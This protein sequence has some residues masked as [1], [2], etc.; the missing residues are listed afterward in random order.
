MSGDL[1]IPEEAVEALMKRRIAE[2]HGTQYTGLHGFA[3]FQRERP[4]DTERLREL[5]EDDIR[6]L[7]PALRKQGAEEE[8]ERL[9]GPF[10]R[11]GGLPDQDEDIEDFAERVENGDA[12]RIAHEIG[13]AL[14]RDQG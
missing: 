14:L 13:T 8:R 5:A 12:Q 1:D 6:V 3:K 7:A 4:A 10:D 2:T 9:R 11:I